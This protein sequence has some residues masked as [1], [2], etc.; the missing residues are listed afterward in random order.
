MP[1]ALPDAM[2]RMQVNGVDIRYLRA[3]S[4]TPVLLMHTLRTQLDMFG[5]LLEQ[6]DTGRVEVIAADLPG[7]GESGAPPVRYTAGYFTDMAEALL[8][9]CQLAG[10]VVV[11]ESIGGAIALGLAAR[12]SPRVARVIAINPYDYGRGAAYAA[13]LRSP[14]CCSPA[15]SGPS[16]ARSSPARKRRGSCGACWRAACTTRASCRRSWS[17]RSIAAARG[18][19]TRARSC[20]CAVSGGA[21]SPRGPATA[22]DPGLRRRRLVTARRTRSQRPRHSRGAHGHARRQWPLLLPGKTARRRQADPRACVTFRFSPWPARPDNS[23][24]RAG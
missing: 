10:T 23:G 9:V 1:L 2:H 13:A 20:R 8:E 5:P 22:G 3:G 6:L 17:R 16:L 15:C 11:G 21:G 19:A 12:R 4:G 18:P 24:R 14:T 7:H